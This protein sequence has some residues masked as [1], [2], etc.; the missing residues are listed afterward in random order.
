M[1][2]DTCSI[3]FQ[4]MKYRESLWPRERLMVNVGNKYQQ[5]CHRSTCF[6][7]TA[8]TLC[9]SPRMWFLDFWRN[10]LLMSKDV[11]SDPPR[12]GSDLAGGYP[13]C[14]PAPLLELKNRSTSNV[15]ADER[16]V[17]AERACYETEVDCVHTSA[18]F[19]AIPATC[20]A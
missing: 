3:H 14:R 8:A 15:S 5:F 10:R 11:K 19:W 9:T 6:E 1:Y 7:R 20:A 13:A 12:F 18:V 2:D 16:A 4:S 17:A